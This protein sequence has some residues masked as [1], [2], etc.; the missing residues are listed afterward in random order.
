MQVEF[1]GHAGICIDSGKTKMVMDGWFSPE[2][3]FD[4]SWYQLPANHHLGQRDWSSLNAVAVSHEHMDHLDPSFL[5]SLP[6][7]IPLYT[8]S[9][10]S[11][12]FTRKLLKNSGRS[13]KILLTGREYKI[14][15][16]QVRIWT[17]TSP[18]NQ[19]S[20]WVFK[21]GGYSIVHTVDSRLT[22]E[23]WDEILKFIGASPNLLLIQCSGAS[24]YPLIY[25]NYNDQTKYKLGLMKREHKLS[26]AFSVAMR[27]KAKTVA[28]CA[29]PPAFL[30]DSLYYANK[31]P[32]FPT[33]GESQKWFLQKGYCDRVEAPLPGDKINLATGELTIDSVMHKAFSWNQVAS[34]IEKYAQ[35]M[36]PHITEVYRRADSLEIRDMDVAIQTHFYRMLD[37]SPYFN[38][39][40]QMKMLL[41]VEGPQGGQWIIHISNKPEVRR[42]TPQES[43]QYC[44][45]LHSR[46]LKRILVDEIPWEDFLLSLRFSAHRN[47]DIYNDHLLGLLKFNDKASLIAVEHYEKSI[48]QE[49]IVVTTVDNSRFEIAKYCPHAGAAMEKAPIEGHQ[50][51][52][53]N[54]HYIFD[55]DTGKCLT[56]N[57][58]LRTKKL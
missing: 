20:V 5:Q 25:E 41:D 36:K 52:C 46:W 45:R 33:P 31:D 56:S 17:E 14:G 37:L 2:G 10:N 35:Q 8:V 6:T 38:E 11:P 23:Q 51:T 12:L 29:G 1:L 9:Y 55:L 34:Y 18:M 47:P 30:D 19:D 7:E 43:Y 21:H 4:A 40:I 16:I 48:S 42:A 39:R 32:S 26:Y 28:I 24:W 57:C 13:S 3:A 50:I 58:N 15:D 27:L 49:T 22:E 54:H 44:Y 53:L